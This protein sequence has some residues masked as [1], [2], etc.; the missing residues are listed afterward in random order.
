MPRVAAHLALG[1]ALGF[2]APVSAAIRT[3]APAPAPTEP[4][5][6]ELDAPMPAETGPDDASREAVP[7]DTA[8][9]AAIREPAPELVP[10]PPPRPV[11]AAEP[12]SGSTPAAVADPCRR[13]G[14]DRCRRIKIGGAMT[15]ALGLAAF[16][17]G[18]GLAATRDQPIDGRPAYSKNY[19]SAGVMAVSV[20]VI[21]I[22]AGALVLREG[23][24]LE[25]RRPALA[26]TLAG[27]TRASAGMGRWP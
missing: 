26:R 18:V 19:R 14:H 4:Q 7:A 9:E 16:G 21:L 1:L 6:A 24:R 25:R 27:W 8:S 2:E 3:V 12:A 10:P 22:V 13:D 23:G 5:P 20:G 11:A 15:T 17:A